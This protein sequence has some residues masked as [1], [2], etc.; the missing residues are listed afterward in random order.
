VFARARPPAALGHESSPTG[1]KKR[2]ESSR[3]PSRAHELGRWCG[4]RATAVKRWWQWNSVAMMH[5]FGERERRVWGEPMEVS[6]FYRG[7]RWCGEVAT[8][9]SRRGNC[10]H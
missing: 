4:G 1:A 5:K 8:D 6:P 9:E 3:N 7:C 2:E 10:C